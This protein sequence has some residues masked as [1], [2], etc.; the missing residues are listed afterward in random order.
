VAA[1]AGAA[2]VGVA[3]LGAAACGRSA[4]TAAPIPVEVVTRRTI[5]VDAQATGVVEPINIIEV[6]SKA[7]GM[8]VRLPV[9]T[10][11]V[12]RAGALLVQVDTR[13]VKNQVEQAAADL[14]SAQAALTVA[15]AQ[16]QRAEGLHAARIIT[17]QE[18]EA[19]QLALTQAQ[20]Q[21]VRATT[22][23]DLAQQRL[24][25]ATVVAPVS[26]TIID[27]PV[28]EGQVIASATGSVTGGTTLLR[29]ADLSRVRV[30]ALVNETDI[31]SIRAGQEARVTV[32][33]YPDR[34][35]DGR[36]E[37]VEPQAVVQQSV[38]M[39]PVIVALE[40]REGLLKPGMNGE[41]SVLVERRTDV[42]A[43]SNDAVRTV[44]EAA[45]AAPLLGLDTDSVAAQLR[46]Q[47]AAAAASAATASAATQPA[48]R[49]PGRASR[50]A[51]GAPAAPQPGGVR[52][53]TAVVF[54]RMAAGGYAPRLVR[55]GATNYDHAEVLAGVVEGD[56][57]ALLNVALLQARREQQNA[58][59][60]AS[61]GGGVPG[62]TAPAGG[63][64]G[65]AGGGAR[66]SGR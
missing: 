25:D 7:S 51:G 3:A 8:I 52:S 26:G 12:V 9:E 43:V 63:A 55:L 18:F 5:V 60:R 20:G 14:R 24:E 10:G 4:P 35:F 27:K 31:G 57:V 30:R 42:L 19:A 32:D 61:T 28:A 56:T 11:S 59:F 39:F 22:N 44:R 38:T 47:Q 33:A 62:M 53:R 23:M 40:N 46:A 6:K 58:R 41:V 48:G 36:V 50:A 45:T 49:P 15:T 29:M 66:P 65:G 1:A 34:P 13:D 54:V 21:I 17:T 16:H 64:A 37:K 2:A